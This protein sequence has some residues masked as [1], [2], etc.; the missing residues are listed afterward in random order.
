ML[1]AH[2]GASALCATQLDQILTAAHWLAGLTGNRD[3]AEAYVAAMI[4]AYLPERPKGGGWT[5]TT[6][7]GRVTAGQ[8][9]LANNSHLEGVGFGCGRLMQIFL[10]MPR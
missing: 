8:V 2:L 4:R 5:V 6:P 9:I 7:K 1:D 10:S 3:A